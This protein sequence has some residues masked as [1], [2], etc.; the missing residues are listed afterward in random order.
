V[1]L[2]DRPVKFNEVLGADTSVVVCTDVLTFFIT[3]RYLFAQDTADQF[4]VA[5]FCVMLLNVAAVFT[6][7][8]ILLDSVAL[9]VAVHPLLAV[10]VRV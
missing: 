2:G 1:V 3:T 6:L 10:T 4:M 9:A 7:G 5:P 8:Q